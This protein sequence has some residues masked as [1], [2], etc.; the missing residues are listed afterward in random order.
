MR[1]TLRATTQV[2]CP[3]PGGNSALQAALDYAYRGYRVLPLYGITASGICTCGK[4]HCVRPGQHLC[5]VH[6][7]CEATTDYAT[8]E[9]W[10][11]QNPSANVGLATGEGLI[12]IEVDPWH[13]GFLEHFQQLYAI[14]DT[15][16]ARTASGSYQLYFHYNQ[17]FV[18]RNTV[19]VL[20]RG[21]RSYG[22]GNFVVAPPSVGLDDH[23]CWFNN[24]GSVRLP[25]VLLPSLLNPRLSNAAWST[26]RSQPSQAARALAETLVKR[27][28]LW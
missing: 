6:S 18:L 1:Q 17:S 14:P 25:S 3:L 8:I 7:Q 20:G 24:L 15:A 26:E 21:V 23:Y 28:L 22:E 2:I 9:S 27:P 19:D 16:Q 5:I 13:G 11:S 12:V 4:R 10:W